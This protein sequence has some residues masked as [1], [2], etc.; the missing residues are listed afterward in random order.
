[1]KSL[2]MIHVILGKKMAK[3]KTGVSTDFVPSR[4]CF[5]LKLSMLVETFGISEFTRSPT[6]RKA[7]EIL[8][9]S[10][11]CRNNEV[12]FGYPSQVKWK[13]TR[14]KLLNVDQSHLQ[15]L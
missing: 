4:D 1:M 7:T 5:V 15:T 14:G 8:R 6:L 9:Q 12:R 11:N 13:M 10:I 3:R 2:F